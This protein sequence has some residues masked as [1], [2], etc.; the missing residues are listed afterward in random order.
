MKEDVDMSETAVAS[1]AKT[2]MV[3]CPLKLL[4]KYVESG[5]KE[6]TDG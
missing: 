1:G 6:G 5:P 3:T 2:L 4:Q